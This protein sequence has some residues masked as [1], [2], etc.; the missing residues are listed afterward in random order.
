MWI[1]KPSQ[2][3]QAPPLEA[4]KKGGMWRITGRAFHRAGLNWELAVHDRKIQGMKLATAP[5]LCD[6]SLK[7]SV[8]PCCVFALLPITNKRAEKCRLH[9]LIG[10]SI[11]EGHGK[12][13]P[14]Q[15]DGII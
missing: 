15:Y 13:N 5:L 8:T 11:M 12:T 9:T 2:I 14:V 6:L 4:Q 1:C 10:V 7:T 3:A